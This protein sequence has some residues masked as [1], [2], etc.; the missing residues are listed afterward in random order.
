MGGRGADLG[1]RGAEDYPISEW[2]DFRSVFGSGDETFPKFMFIT[3][4]LMNWLDI[5]VRHV[6]LVQKVAWDRHRM[7]RIHI[8]HSRCC[9]DPYTVPKG[10]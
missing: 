4:M 8:G 6:S 9:V 10:F 7:F 1:G 2:T 3:P 5:R